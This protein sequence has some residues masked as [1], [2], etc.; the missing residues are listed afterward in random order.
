MLHLLLVQV[1]HAIRLP[2]SRSCDGGRSAGAPGDEP[3]QEFMLTAVV[4]HRGLSANAGHY[5]ADVWDS[6][7]CKLHAATRALQV[8][9]AMVAC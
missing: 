9:G 8:Q 3:G 1:P 5:V 2:V 4:Y 6:V 7:C